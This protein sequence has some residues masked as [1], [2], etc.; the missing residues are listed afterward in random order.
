MKTAFPGTLLILALLFCNNIHAQRTTPY[1]PIVH[2]QPP[3]QHSVGQ[4]I[5]K[6]YTGTIGGRKVSVDLRYGYQGASNYGG[7]TYYFADEDERTLFFIRQPPAFS[8]DV[9]LD[10]WEVPEDTSLIGESPHVSPGPGWS[11]RI[12]GDELNGTWHNTAD[13]EHKDVVLR[14]DYSNSCPMEIVF[15]GGGPES[16][17]G[18]SFMCAVPSAKMNKDDASFIT[19]EQIRFFDGDN[20][21]IKTWDRFVIWKAGNF[22]G[23]YFLPVYNDN[24]ILVMESEYGSN[25]TGDHKLNYLCLDVRNHKRF[26]ADDMLNI[27][28]GKLSALLEDAV[29]TK[30]NIPADVP[31]SARLLREKIPHAKNVYPVHSGLVFCYNPGELVKDKEVVV[32]IPYRKLDGI[33][34]PGFSKRMGAN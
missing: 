24:G 12:E 29:R 11:F 10:S 13:L 6:H 18:R 33:L 21:K 22:E 5:Y 17:S 20:T 2:R 7:S 34:R 31:L 3:G 26:S 32:H 28:S 8:H 19:A 14:E 25:I 23:T 16:E 30:Y 15:L 4:D 27:G 9:A 1:N